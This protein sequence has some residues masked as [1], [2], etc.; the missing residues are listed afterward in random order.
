MTVSRRG[1]ASY[2]PFQGLRSELF[3][4]LAG[5]TAGPA[6]CRSRC[7]R[8]TSGHVGLTVLPAAALDAA[9]ARTSSLAQGHLPAQA[10]STAAYAAKL[11][12]ARD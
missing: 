5:H 8:A 10:A 2:D 11:L 3:N 12:A 7:T 4:E 9:L 1:R 6:G